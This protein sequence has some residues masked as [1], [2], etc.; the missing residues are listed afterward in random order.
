MNDLTF[1]QRNGYEDVPPQLRPNEV[2]AGFRAKLKIYFL[3]MYNSNKRTGIG[4]QFKW[5]TKLLPEFV[6]MLNEFYVDYIDINTANMPARDDQHAWTEVWNGY[7]DSAPINKMFDALEFFISGKQ[8]MGNFVQNVALLCEKE[9]LAYRLVDRQFIQVGSQEECAACL[10]ALEQTKLLGADGIR[11]HLVDAG[12]DLRNGRWAQSVV[13]SISAVES[14]AKK[15]AGDEKATLGSALS[16]IDDLNPTLK[17]GFS[18]LYGYT[19]DEKGLRHALSADNSDAKVD[20]T[21]AIYML[22]A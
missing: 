12:V 5:F 3:N 7:L 19:S 1:S 9:R 16:K 20:E 13:N 6:D 11:K 10:A 17:K 22:G 15:I 4:E 14:A 2:S 8:E 21:D 18:I